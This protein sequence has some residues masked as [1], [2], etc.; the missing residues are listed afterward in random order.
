MSVRPA[1]ATDK[2]MDIKKQF[3]ITNQV[4][5]Q[6]PSGR[7]MDRNNPA[8]NNLQTMPATLASRRQ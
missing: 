8:S 4:R 1:V 5:H 2:D 3:R 6:H 7:A